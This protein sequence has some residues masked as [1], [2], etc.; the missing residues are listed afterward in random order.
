[1]ARIRFGLW[2]LLSIVTAVLTLF[3]CSVREGD[4]CNPIEDECPSGLVCTTPAN[5][6]YP[7]CCPQS[8]PIS[9]SASKECPAGA[10][11]GDAGSD[12]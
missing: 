8:G 12:V 10:G 7:V 5:C 1:M 4:R 3:A 9:N 6:G 11:G 2:V